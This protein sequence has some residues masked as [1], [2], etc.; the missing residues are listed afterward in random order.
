MVGGHGRREEAREERQRKKWSLTTQ[1]KP[2]YQ[3]YKGNE[4]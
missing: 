1:N 2:A 3:D 4:K